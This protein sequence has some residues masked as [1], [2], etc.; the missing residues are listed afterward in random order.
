MLDIVRQC[1]NMSLFACCLVIAVP[2][3]HANAASPIQVSGDGAC[4]SQHCDI[5]FKTTPSSGS[6]LTALSCDGFVAGATP[7]AVG[8]TWIA[9]RV[10]DGNYYLAPQITA[11]VGNSTW[12]VAN[13]LTN[14]M[15]ETGAEFE[16]TAAFAGTASKAAFQCTALLLPGG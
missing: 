3:T 6:T 10:A 11:Q 5:L 14:F 13:G 2:G 12:F 7:G 16:A 15:L 8:V 1:F 4:D 9:V